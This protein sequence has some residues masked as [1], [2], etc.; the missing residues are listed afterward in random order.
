[1]DPKELTAFRKQAGL[2]LEKLAQQLD[3]TSSTVWRWERQKD[4]IPKL[5][6]Y[7]IE[8][9]KSQCAPVQNKITEITLAEPQCVTWSAL[10]TIAEKRGYFQDVGLSVTV[11]PCETARSALKQLRDK[12]AT[13]AFAAKRLVD[14]MLEDGEAVNLSTIMRSERAIKGI[15]TQ[16]GIY[17]LE[18]FATDIKIIFYPQ[19]SDVANY[20]NEVIK[21]TFISSRPALVA[22]QQGVT[23]PETVVNQMMESSVSR[24][25]CAFFGWEPYVHWVEKLAETSGLPIYKVPETISARYAPVAYDVAVDLKFAAE[26]SQA[27]GG[28]IS[29]LIMAEET[30]ESSKRDAVSL[31]SKEL[32]M[33]E[34]RVESEL[35]S[36]KF[37]CDL[38]HKAI[39]KIWKHL[40]QS[41]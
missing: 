6:E 24:E 9:L 16:H 21:T 40:S 33:A 31:L 13:M 37:K 11:I 23:L 14:E 3:V 2:S 38:N 5:V 27:I 8:H 17:D 28:F 19:V 35:D 18:Q 39:W 15:N 7:A 4:P 26:N 34:S 41:Q 25:A 36:H 10:K 20:L 1:M 29:A 30:I 12:N 22:I 32:N